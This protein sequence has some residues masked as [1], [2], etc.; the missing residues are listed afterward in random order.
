[1]ARRSIGENAMALAY[2]F[3]KAKVTGDPWLKGT[4]VHR[5]RQYHVHANLDVGGEAWDVAVNVGTD[6]S[7]DLLQYKLV[8]DYHHPLTG[9]L[10][11]ATAGRTDLTG[12]S[13]L[14]AL[15]FLRSDVLAET[16]IW[17][18]SDIMDGSE[19]VEPVKS[20]MR[21]LRDA[22]RNRLNVYIF[23]RF[24]TEG[25]GLHDVHMNQGSTTERF[26]H[27]PNDDSNDHNDVWQDGAMLID[28]G[29]ERWA[30]YFT[31]FQNQLVPT[32]DLG[33][34]VAGAKPIA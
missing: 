11:E 28:L 25:N 32:D 29:A 33:N 9:Q 21:L 22:R 5:E 12:Q 23:G 14:P 16:G 7:D 27:R 19:E 10:A 2:G 26:L 20:M 1:M 15:D 18:P 8:F 6:D 13:T 24:Y 34:P 17:R 31:A 30:G 3:A 4:T